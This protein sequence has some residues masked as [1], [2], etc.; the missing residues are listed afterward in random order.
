MV[1]REEKM[2]VL[3]LTNVPSPYRVEFFNQLGEFCELTVLYQKRRS[4]ERDEKWIGK[5]RNTF[6]SIYLKG[7]S[8]GVDQTISFNVLNYLN[9]DKYDYFVIC[10]LASPTEMIALTWCKIKKIPYYFESDGGFVKSGKGIK[11]AIKRFNLLGAKKYFSTGTIH[12][13]YYISYGVSRDKIFHYPFSSVVYEDILKKPISIEDKK[14]LRDRCGYSYPILA[15]TVGQFIYRKGMDILI[16]A[17][18]NMPENCCLLIIGGK[19]INDY[20]DI[21]KN[22]KNKNIR[23]IPF[24]EK[25][26]LSN[27]YRMSDFFVFPTREDI[28][29]LV[30]N[31][32][33]SF[34]LPVISSNRAAAAVELVKDSLNG[35][36]FESENVEKLEEKLNNYIKLPAEDKYSMACNALNTA[37]EYTIEKMVSRHL[38]LFK[39]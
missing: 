14:I 32:A 2:R 8:T 27:Y 13:N 9:K 4:S 33:L 23:F 19:P 12:D 30:V 20:I 34:G 37:H 15:I 17:W 29:G 1:I 6:K 38:E 25:D 7:I 39:S 10:G 36:L 31:E 5:S 22:N 28:W 26:E 18:R 35:F 16:K 21:M 3:F 11:E 24:I